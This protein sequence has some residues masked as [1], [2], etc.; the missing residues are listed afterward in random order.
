MIDNHITQL[1]EI[2]RG[3]ERVIPLYTLYDVGNHIDSFKNLNTYNLTTLYSFK[4]MLSTGVDFQLER[5]NEFYLLLSDKTF[6]KK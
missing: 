6:T 4:D 5:N 2:Q 3:L 1:N